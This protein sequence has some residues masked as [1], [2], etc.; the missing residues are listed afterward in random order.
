[1]TTLTSPTNES[2]SIAYS[3]INTLSEESGIADTPKQT[4]EGR[5]K[6]VEFESYI[7]EE[8]PKN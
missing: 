5:K 6:Y 8:R 3:N 4:T 2:Y 1:M 7:D